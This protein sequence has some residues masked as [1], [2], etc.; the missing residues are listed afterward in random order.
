MI[1]NSGV[2]LISKYLA[3]QASSYASHI[4]IGSG[5]RPL[6]NGQ[7]IAVMG[8]STISNVSGTGPY[9]ATVT[10]TGVAGSTNYT[11]GYIEVGDVVSSPPVQPPLYPGTLGTGVVTV[12]AITGPK[13]FTV[14]STS[15]ITA[16]ATTGISV[17]TNISSQNLSSKTKLDFEMARFPITSRSYVVDKEV[18]SCTSLIISGTNQITVATSVAHPFGVGDTVFIT[19]V[20]YQTTGP[21]TDTQVNGM[22]TITSTTSLGFVATQYDS[23]LGD[24]GSSLWGSL[25]S[26]NVYTGYT[27]NNSLFNAT[28]Y[29]KQISLTAEISDIAKY[30]ITELGLYSLGS[31]QYTTNSDSRTLLNFSRGENWEYV[32]GTSGT[33]SEIPYVTSMIDNFAA[34]PFFASSNDSWWT[35]DAVDSYRKYRQEKPRMLEDALIVRGDMSNYD[36]VSANNFTT[37]SNYIVFQNPGIDLSRSAA[38]DEISIAF[39]I[40][41]AQQA[42]SVVPDSYYIMLEFGYGNG[43]DTARFTFADSNPGSTIIGGNRYM[44]LTQKMSSMVATAGFNW[45][46]VTSLKIYSS[47]EVSG[48][49]TNQFAIVLDALRFDNVSTQNPLYALTAYTIVNTSSGQ[50][51][52]KKANSNDLI[53]FRLD[54]A[55]GQ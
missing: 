44:V 39:S 36:G 10:I 53:N 30:D 6:F 21:T 26:T 11:V 38:T 25:P 43:T 4:A 48:T 55:I 42:I 45:Q 35:S 5:P 54:F 13:T 3:G 14:S 28:V 7:S 2:E 9:T 1:T 27:Y 23:T 40:A 32:D 19:D 16:G 22:Y 37:T 15:A 49:P 8:S 17:T 34:T 29:T 12:T 41:N 31:N 51:L 46:N 52:S 33:T 50:V 24:W 20:D 47:I 18:A